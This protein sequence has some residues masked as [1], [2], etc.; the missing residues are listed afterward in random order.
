MVKKRK[1]RAELY[2]IN[3]IIVNP[4]NNHPEFKG[5]SCIR[6]MTL[7]DN[8]KKSYI[9]YRAVVDKDRDM[10]FQFVTRGKSINHPYQARTP[11]LPCIIMQEAGHV[12]FNEGYHPTVEQRIE[13]TKYVYNCSSDELDRL[14][15]LARL[16]G[17]RY[18]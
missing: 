7:T 16:R 3:D 17:P 12:L 11:F 9:Y 1:A 10:V 13:I 15:L 4:E 5:N 6:R 14:S 18:V 2:S 8:G